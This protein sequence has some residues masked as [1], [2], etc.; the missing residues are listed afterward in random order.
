VSLKVDIWLYNS[1]ESVEN[2]WFYAFFSEKN[3]KPLLFARMLRFLEVPLRDTAVCEIILYE[4]EKMIKTAEQMNEKYRRL[5][6]T[7]TF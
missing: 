5:L 3:Q 2:I 4:R 6:R 1:A 7:H